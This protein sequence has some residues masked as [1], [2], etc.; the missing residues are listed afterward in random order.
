M[1]LRYWI[2]LDEKLVKNNM[3]NI[4]I[5]FKNTAIADFKK[6]QMQRFFQKFFIAFIGLGFGTVSIVM[7]YDYKYM[8]ISNPAEILEWWHSFLFQG[9]FATIFAFIGTNNICRE[10]EKGMIKNIVLTGV[11]L[12]NYLFA[13]LIVFFLVFS[14]IMMMTSII[15]TGALFIYFG[16]IFDLRLTG[17]G[18]MITLLH[19]LQTLFLVMMFSSIFKKTIHAIAGLLLYYLVIEKIT[20]KILLS[21]ASFLNLSEWANVILKHTPLQ[22]LDNLENAYEMNQYLINFS[23][24]FV[25]LGIY[26]IIIWLNSRNTQLGLINK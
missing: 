5:L 14:A 13:R 22:V 10:Y 26:G 7:F 19:L 16:K 9:T 3:N 12:S 11:G 24:F 4:F 25:Y 21:M 15:D 20:V 23:L 8:K 6:F 2:K 1:N 18:L 17:K